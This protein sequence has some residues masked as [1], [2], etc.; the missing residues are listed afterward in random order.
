MNILEEQ[1]SVRLLLKPDY[2][3]TALKSV[4]H[5][6]FLMKIVFSRR[7]MK[8]NNINDIHFDIKN[9]L[10]YLL[11]LCFDKREVNLYSIQVNAKRHHIYIDI[12]RYSAFNCLII[13]NNFLIKN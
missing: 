6:T 12:V 10:L 5:V 4:C 2:R 3:S 13:V 9:N 8:V 1:I 11:V 7:N